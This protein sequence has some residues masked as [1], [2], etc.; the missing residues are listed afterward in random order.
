MNRFLLSAAAGFFAFF[1]LVPSA[2]ALGWK[3]VL[4]M[5]EAGIADSLILQKIEY[6]GTTFRLNADEMEALKGAGVSDPV[7]SAMLR[8]E[9]RDEDEDIGYYDRYD[10][11]PYYY[12]H[13]RVYVG[14]GLGYHRLYPWYYDRYWYP[15]YGRLGRPYYRPRYPSYYRPYSGYRDRFT[16]PGLPPTRYRTRVESRID[17]HDRGF[18]GY[19][20]RPNPATPRAGASGRADRRPR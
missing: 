2:S 10:D 3:D 17:T 18:P 9:A 13:P 6:S 11:Y 12:T 4:Q 15:R 1:V 19:R 16:R 5:H 14:F 8:T 20:S 7:I